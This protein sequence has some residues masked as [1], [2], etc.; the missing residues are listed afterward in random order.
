MTKPVPLAEARERH[1]Q[2]TIAGLVHVVRQL[3][4][5][6]RVDPTL[7]D[8]LDRLLTQGV[9]LMAS[10]QELSDELDAIKTAVDAS[11]VTAQEQIDLIKALQDQI[12]AGTPVSQ[13]QLDELDA[14]A[15][16]ILASLSPAA[17]TASTS[18]KRSDR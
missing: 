12:A 5:P 4:D 16:G 2:D 10:V 9:T 3:L 15:D 17:S 8:K 11:K 14:K 6:G 1:Y 7:H 18:S 13:Q